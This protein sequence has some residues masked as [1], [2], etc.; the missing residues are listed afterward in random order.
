MPDSHLDVSEIYDR[1]ARAGYTLSAADARLRGRVSRDHDA[2][3]F[4]HARVLRALVEEG[5]LSVKQL[6]KHTETTG[7]AV[8]QLVNGLVDA[9]YVARERV[10]GDR[11]TVLVTITESGRRRH[12]ERQ[13]KMDT[14]FDETFARFSPEELGAATEILAAIAEFYDRL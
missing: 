6:T 9:G 12:L 4:T 11:R 1:F 8:T 2:L 3:S 10:E 7:A 14:A 5:P 13:R